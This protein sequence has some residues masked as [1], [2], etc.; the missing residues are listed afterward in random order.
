MTK[1][2]YASDIHV[3]YNEY[4]GNGYGVGFRL[5]KSADYLVIAGDIS[6]DILLSIRFLRKVQRTEHYKR[7]VFIPGNHEYYNLE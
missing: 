6:N 7:I 1:I 5:K 2:Q 4:P 3:D